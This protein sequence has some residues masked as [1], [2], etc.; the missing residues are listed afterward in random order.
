M[1]E[2]SRT[3]IS[4]SFL[5]A[6]APLGLARPKRKKKGMK[7]FQNS[8]FLLELD[9]TCQ[10][11]LELVRTCENLSKLVKT[12]QNFLELVRTCPNLFV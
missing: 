9:I 1:R 10:N 4:I 8:M 2:P 3:R 7:K 12:C 6:K 11:L 5:G